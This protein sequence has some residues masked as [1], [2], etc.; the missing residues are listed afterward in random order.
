MSIVVD[1]Q[2]LS[3]YG[4]LLRVTMGQ[5]RELSVVDVRFLCQG[6]RDW[7]FDDPP[8]RCPAKA[9]EY[10]R[11]AAQSFEHGFM[12]W[13]EQPDRFYIFFADNH[14]FVWLDAPYTAKPGTPVD[15][16]PPPGYVVPVSGFGKLWRDEIE[17]VSDHRVRERLGWATEA[18]FAFDTAYQCEV[19]GYPRMWNCYL[20]APSGKVLLLYP[21]STV[22]VRF[23]W[24]ER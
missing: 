15:E 20:R 8:M 1:E 18:E 3:Y 22:R 19:E 21:E 10:S 4:L 6:L 24:R 12:I 16:T 11:A 7:F 23:L 2:M 9:A 14:E 17:G 13:T 5:S